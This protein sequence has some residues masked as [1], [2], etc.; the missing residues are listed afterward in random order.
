[1]CDVHRSLGVSGVTLMHKINEWINKSRSAK[2]AYTTSRPLAMHLRIDE[3][4]D[5]GPSNYFHWMLTGSLVTIDNNIEMLF[6]WRPSNYWKYWVSGR[7]KRNWPR[8]TC[9]FERFW[10][11]LSGFWA[12]FQLFEWVGGGRGAEAAI[13]DQH[14]ERTVLACCNSWN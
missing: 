5:Q 10:A 9:N 6:R 8:W 11:I 13:V 1:M 3:Y 7:T 2:L 14:F 4:V 12:S